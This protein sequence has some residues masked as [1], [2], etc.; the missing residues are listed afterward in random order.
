VLP[1]MLLVHGEQHGKDGRAR[2]P[3][4]G[5]V[6]G[7]YRPK[8]H[9]NPAKS[10]AVPL[11]GRSV[12]ATPVAGVTV[13]ASAT[14]LGVLVQPVTTTRLHS[15]ADARP[16]LRVRRRRP[17]FTP[18]PPM[19][20][21]WQKR[22]AALTSVHQRCASLHL[23]SMGR[24][25][26]MTTDGTSAT[27]YQAEFDGLPSSAVPSLERT[28]AGVV[29]GRRPG[30]S[31][32]LQA[33]SC[34][35]QHARVVLAC[36]PLS[37]MLLHVMPN[38]SVAVSQCCA[39]RHP[40]ILLQSLYP[41]TWTCLVVVRLCATLTGSHLPSMRLNCVFPPCLPFKSSSLLAAPICMTLLQ[42]G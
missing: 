28:L 18:S 10:S 13:V 17:P 34:M 31:P 39:Q 33:G 27:F 7:Q 38:G 14:P 29:D 30:Q 41:M 26:C 25:L 12:S 22:L 40:T 16:G 32:V 42:A 21:A 8:Q 19:T 36:Y 1:S 9:A 20:P 5:P 35:A 24:G 15:S 4:H 11:Y 3:K 37:R 6:C 23:S 2:G